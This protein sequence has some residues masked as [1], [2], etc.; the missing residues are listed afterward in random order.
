MMA[1]KDGAYIGPFWGAPLRYSTGRDHLGMQAT[2]VA[3]YSF[4][5]P[6]LTN[7]TQRA[8]YYS[9]YPWLVEQYAQEKRSSSVTEFN[10]F[11]RRGELLYAFASIM[12]DSEQRS[13]VGSLFVRTYL[14]ENGTPSNSTSINLAEYADIEKGKKTYWQLSGGGFTQYYMGPLIDIGILARAKNH[15]IPVA[16]DVGREIAKYFEH[17]IGNEAKEVI[18]SSIR[19]GTIRYS[20]LSKHLP[21]ILPDRI[22]ATGQEALMLLQQLIPPATDLRGINRREVI[23]SYLS[24]LNQD[25][26]SDGQYDLP[27]AIYYREGNNKNSLSFPESS[28]SL[29]GWR[30]Y[31]ISEY[32]HYA[33]EYIMFYLLKFLHEEGGWVTIEQCIDIIQKGILKEVN[34]II[35]KL[36]GITKTT[37]LSSVSTKLRAYNKVSRSDKGS[38][39]WLMPSR[40]EYDENNLARA[41]MLLLAI[42]TRHEEELDELF[43]YGMTRNIIREKSFWDILKFCSKELETPLNSFLYKLVQRHIISC[44]LDV[45]YRKMRGDMKNTLKFQY[46]NA[47]LSGLEIVNPV[48]TSPRILSVLNF[49]KDLGLISKENKPTKNGLGRINDGT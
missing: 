35:P 29:Y 21:S 33:L 20:D 12:I 39:E 38:P 9:Y 18:L 48:M 13:V 15:R 44:H 32:V 6:G 8:R 11:M 46:E 40:T 36:K 14:K 49:I 26:I 7:L 1:K 31:Q 3:T 47:S 41:L 25:S 24:Y 30:F 16:T 17:S 19:S 27:R 2:S 5:V 4:L 34:N 23:L 22:D 37:P 28:G 42:Y 43:H 10:N 45:S